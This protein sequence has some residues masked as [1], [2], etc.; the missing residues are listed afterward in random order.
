MM[1]TGLILCVTKGFPIICQ[2]R[3]PYV[4][5]LSHHNHTKHS[6]SQAL[7]TDQHSRFSGRPDELWPDP[8]VDTA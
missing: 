7:F 4:E 2:R 5:K 1:E 3:S 8:P 6:Q